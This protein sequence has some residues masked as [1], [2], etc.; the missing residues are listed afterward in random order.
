MY[1]HIGSGEVVKKSA[2]IGVFD[3]DTATIARQTKIFL[4]ERENK[5]ELTYVTHDIP[6]SFILCDDKVVICD[7]NTSTVKNRSKRER[8]INGKHK[9]V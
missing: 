7:L 5:G 1:I 3:M 4:R 2:V 6:R 8:V 9:R